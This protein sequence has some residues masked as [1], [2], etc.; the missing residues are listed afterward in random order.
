MRQDEEKLRQAQAEAAKR[1][2]E[3]RIAQEK[4]DAL[5]RQMEQLKLQ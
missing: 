1:A 4:S 3:E 5:R 2:E